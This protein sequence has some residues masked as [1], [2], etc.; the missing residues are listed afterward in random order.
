MYLTILLKENNCK[1]LQKIILYYSFLMK[2]LLILLVAFSYN[3]LSSDFLS[4]PHKRFDIWWSAQNE[5]KLSRRSGTEFN[6][7]F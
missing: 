6:C 7:R 5:S 2:N 3:L 1:G 4:D